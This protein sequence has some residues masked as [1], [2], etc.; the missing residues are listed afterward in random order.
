MPGRL[1]KIEVK[2]KKG[3]GGGGGGGGEKKEREESGATLSGGRGML[4]RL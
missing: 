1:F 2:I 4:V 3:G